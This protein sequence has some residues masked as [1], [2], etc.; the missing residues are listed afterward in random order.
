MESKFEEAKL[1]ILYNDQ[2]K[3]KNLLDEVIKSALTVM[4]EQPKLSDQAK[5]IINKANVELVKTTIAQR[6]ESMEKIKMGLEQTCP[7]PSVA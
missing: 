3:A 7:K 2:T 5:E 6:D 1:A 4:S